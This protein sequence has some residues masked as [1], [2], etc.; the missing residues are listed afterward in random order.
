MSTELESDL[1]LEIAHVVFIDI[2]GYS[3]LLINEQHECLRDLNRI[4]RNTDAFQGADSAGKLTCLPTGDG[5]ALAF[6]TTPDAPVRCALQIG[7]ALRNQPVLKVRMGVHSGPVNGMTDVNDRSNFAGAGINIAQRVMDCGDAGHILLSKRV[8]EDLAQYRHWQPC[9]HNL[10]ECEVKHGEVIF[11]VNLYTDEVGNPDLPAKFKPSPRARR[12][13]QA[14]GRAHPVSWRHTFFG[15]AFLVIAAAA[16]GFWFFGIP[17]KATDIPPGPNAT[18]ASSIPDKSIAVLPFDNLSANPETAFFTEGVQDEILSDLAKIADLKVISRT[19]VMQYKVVRARNLREIGRQLGVA[20]VL[21]GSVQRIDNRI[22]I[23]AQL[24]DAR[25]DAHLWAQTYDREVADVFAIQSEIAATIADQLKIQLS[26]QER[27]ALARPNTTDLLAQRLFVQA[28]QLVVLASNP[29][30][31]ESLLQAIPMLEEAITRD[32]KFIGAYGLL[33]TAQIDLYWQGFDHTPERLELARLAIERAAR[34]NPDAG[35]VHLSRGDYLYKAF[36]DYDGA[37]AELDIA[38]VSLP[39]NP[40]G[41]IYTAAIDRRQ[42]RWAESLRNM[43]RGVALDPR[44]FRFVIETAFTYQANRRYAES[45]R[46]FERAASILPHDHFARTQLAQNVFLERGDLEPLRAVLSDIVN[47]DPKAATEIANGLFTCA[48]AARNAAGVTR[49]LQSIRAEGLR[50]VYNNSLWARDWF[51]GLAARTFGDV[52]RAQT[53]FTAARAIEEINVRNQPDYAPAWSRLGLIDA[54]FG[55]KEDAIREGRRAC[56][57]LPVTK[58][59]LDGPSY[60]TNLAV[61]YAWTGEKNLALEQLAL[62]ASL[63][64]GVSYG[65]LKL[66]PQWDSLRDDPRF[67]K[68][69]ASIAPAKQNVETQKH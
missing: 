48:L 17:R 56:E 65:E 12:A 43:E 44:N 1:Q 15:V 45:D 28:L 36:R 38:R 37:R 63:P 32:P 46:M 24:I 21:E 69:L 41:Y 18:P 59:A 40:V 4:V 67:E 50:D 23:N 54:G 25:T 14:T 13:P 60:I 30:A 19:S 62:S 6:A 11:L 3:K 2:V 33:Y 57:L 42:G 64:G 61:I 34:V 5:M 31:K 53:A 55:R 68:I 8:A 66:F 47:E 35:E 27:A 22:R 58:D 9:L 52:E 20:H 51:I 29:D 49:A 10:G 16:V 26:P 7:K 39:N